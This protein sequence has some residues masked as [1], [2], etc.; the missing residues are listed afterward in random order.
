MPTLEE[1]TLAL[2]GPGAP[3]ALVTED[4]VGVPMRVL[5]DRPRSLRELLTRTL[6]FEHRDFLV[7]GERRIDYREH[8]ARV[9]ALARHLADEHGVRAGDRVAILG[10]NGPEWIVSFFAVTSLGAIA[11]ALNGWWSGEELA[12]ALADSTPRLLIADRKRLARVPESARPAT[13]LE[14]ETHLADLSADVS[15]PGVLPEQ[16]IGE[17]DPACILYTSGTTGRAKGA[18]LSHRAL[19]AGVGLQTLN[20]AAAAIASG[21]TPSTTPPC[22]L[23]TTPLFHVSGLVAGVLMMAS[24]GAKIVMR[25]GRFDPVDVMRLI[26]RERVTTWS[27]TP[28]MS[29]QVVHHPDVARFDLSS[30]GHLGSGGSPLSPEQQEKIRETLPGIR[31]GLGYGLTES[32]GVATINAGADLAERPSSAGRA[33]PGVEVEVR[34]DDGAPVAEGEVGEV[35]IRSPLVMLGYWQNEAAT[36]EALGDD[37]WL[38]TGDVGRLENGH[39][40]IDAR[41]RDLILRGGENVYPIEVEQAIEACPGVDEA[42]VLGVDHPVLGQEVKAFVVPKPGASLDTKVLGAAVSE[43]IAAFKTPAHWVILD[44]PLP[45]NASGKVLKPVLAERGDDAEAAG[46]AS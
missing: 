9:A 46:R 17:D 23:L 19:L 33:M 40:M 6:G 27:T 34:D 39:L 22:T 8:H 38:R 2:T 13:V 35:W 30:L 36:R 21:A 37:R 20:G 25:D 44:A 26:E 32:G 43:R 16:K 11:V 28:T 7:I 15:R 3:F 12:H 18:V 1:A 31:I 45:R 10:A 5:A 42:A 4:V 29:H 24:I 41:A 14:M